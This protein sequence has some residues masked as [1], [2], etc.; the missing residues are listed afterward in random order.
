MNSLVTPDFSE[1]SDRIEAGT[2]NMRISSH[3]VDQ[4]AGKEGKPPTAYI[5]WEM[6]TFGEAEEKNNGRKYTHRTPINGPGAFRL[7]DF[8]AAAGLTEV[9]SD[10]FDPSMLYG[11]ELTVVIGQQKDKPEYTEVKAV[12]KY[13]PK[14]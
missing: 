11:T 8:L 7:K 10:G 6:Q 13:L 12:Q 2:Y 1:V 14:V 3:K 9:P 5:A 4:W